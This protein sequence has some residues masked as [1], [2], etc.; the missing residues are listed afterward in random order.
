MHAHRLPRIGFEGLSVDN[1]IGI[2]IAA[3]LCAFLSVL[4]SFG[5]GGTV[6][7]SFVTLSLSSG[8]CFVA[9]FRFLPR[10]V[11]IRVRLFANGSVVPP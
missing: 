2:G 9:V 1:G 4:F 8:C 7:A 10:L 6:F 11:R 5:W 3:G